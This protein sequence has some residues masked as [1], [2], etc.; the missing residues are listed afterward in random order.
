MMKIKNLILILVACMLA[1]T[2]GCTSLG[3]NTI[4]MER[5]KMKYANVESKIIE[6]D[7]MNIHYKDE[8]HGPTLILVHGVCASLHTWDGWVD[9]LKSHYRVIRFDIPGFGLTGPASDPSL[10]QIDGAVNLFEKIVTEMK[11]EKFYLAGN[12]LGGYISWKYTLKNPNKVEKL[13]LIDSVGFPQELPGIIA[14]ASNPVVRPFARHAIP[15]YLIDRSVMQVYGD[16]SKVT[17]ELQDRYFELAMREGNKGGMI[18]VFTEFRRQSKDKHLSDGIKDIK[19]PT[20]VMW[21]TKDTWIPFKYF[22]SWKAELPNAKFI[23]YEGAGHTP[24]EELPDQTAHDADLF[25][26]G[27]I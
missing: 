8:G 10:Y 5:L 22:A 9:Q 14:F 11:L 21:G 23:Q 1:A 4:P 15:R 26:S 18:D 17:K 24:M 2:L 13:I 7:G 20:L 6:I 27:K 25:L 16:K 19:P 3:M 12:S